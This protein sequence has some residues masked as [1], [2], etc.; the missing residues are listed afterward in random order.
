MGLALSSVSDVI[1]PV[2]LNNGLLKEQKQ[3]K[4]RFEK[5][6]LSKQDTPT[7]VLRGSI[8]I[9]R[10]DKHVGWLH[11][12]IFIGQ[13]FNAIIYGRSRDNLNLCH[14]EMILGVNDKPG[15]EGQ[16]LLA[17]ALFDGIKT[18]SE[19]HKK[20]EVITGIVAFKPVDERIRD[21][22]AKFAEQT[23]VNF[24]AAGLDPK[25]KDFKARLKREVNGFNLS[26]MLTSF[27]YSQVARPTESVQELAAYA[28]ADLL[29]GD[30][31]RDKEGNLKPY[32]CTAYL[33]TLAQGAS[34][35]SAL[36]EDEL[37]TLK[38]KRRDEAAKLIFERIKSRRGGDLLA[39]TY[40]D[41]EFMQL[42]PSSAM[43]YA[44][45]DVFD[46]AAAAA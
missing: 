29:R 21:I 18:T 19:N 8:A 2:M 31:L 20:D 17:H 13:L 12:L 46:R 30:K 40:W 26:K 43:S 10:D 44:T 11:V 9:T 22:F 1:K 27:F 7:K 16:L 6:V 5:I 33:L 45:G 37:K 41:N 3:S 42:D 23:A 28:A 15:K 35:V 24:K 32:Y 25:T 4:I 34:L 14:W 39:A 38:E 36:S